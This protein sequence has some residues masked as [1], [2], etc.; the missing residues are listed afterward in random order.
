MKY[1]KRVRELRQQARQAAA[2][3][4]VDE[5]RAKRAEIAAMR[6]ARGM[7]ARGA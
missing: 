6:Q 5:A 1:G 2:T 3:G 4:Q 7:K